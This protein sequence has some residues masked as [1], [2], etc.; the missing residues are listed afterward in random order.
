[1]SSGDKK[2]NVNN[3]SIHSHTITKK[4]TSPNKVIPHG[5]RSHERSKRKSPEP[6]PF[7]IK[8]DKSHSPPQQSSRISAN[9]ISK[10]PIITSRIK[11]KLN[12]DNLELIKDEKDEKYESDSEV[13]IIDASMLE[14]DVKSESYVDTSDIDLGQ[15]TDVCSHINVIENDGLVICNDCQCELYQEQNCDSEFNQCQHLHVIRERGILICEDCALELYEEINHEQEWRHFPDSDNRGETDPSRCQYRKA[16]E[17]GIKK[18]L[19]RMGFAPDVCDVADKSYMMITE[20]EVKK[21]ELRKGIMFACVFEAHKMLKRPATPEDISSKFFNLER[22]IMS[23]GIT[24]YR[25]RC[26]RSFFHY[27]DITAKHFIPTIMKMPQFNAKPEHIERVI[28]LYEKIKDKC[29]TINRSNPQSASKAIIYYYFRHRGVMIRPDRFG[30]IVGLS[31]I[32]LLRLAN[33]ISQL[34]NTTKT[35]SLI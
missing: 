34:L 1:M 16:P 4:I 35:V 9:N 30:R 6:R 3:E 18:E 26:P 8:R 23:Q 7:F 22:K 32:I 31:H 28:M 12:H 17:K 21:S 19:E 5:F 11:N 33:A 15:I 14:D 29:A 10:S 13:G 20:G 27:E 25:L 2:V 24:F